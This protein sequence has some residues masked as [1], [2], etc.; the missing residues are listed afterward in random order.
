MTDINNNPASGKFSSSFPG[1]GNIDLPLPTIHEKRQSAGRLGGLTTF[2]RYGIEHYR[3]IGLKGGRPPKTLAQR[4]HQRS[5]E[6]K[7]K[8]RRTGYPTG[9]LAGLKRLF[10]LRQ[11]GSSLD[12]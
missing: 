1:K 5:S 11:A 10:R 6:Q 9:D 12:S 2:L 8:D 4:R 3:E 7:I